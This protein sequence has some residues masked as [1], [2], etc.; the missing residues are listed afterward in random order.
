LAN[1]ETEADVLIVGETGAGKDLVARTMHAM[2]A[3]KNARFVAIDCGAIP[4]PII[5]SELFGHEQGAFTGAVRRRI[6]KFEYDQAGPCSLMKSRACPR[7]CRLVYF[8]SC[9]IAWSREWDLIKGSLSTS[10]S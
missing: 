5:E 4:E 10:G 6:G 9:K 7:T 8:A 1:A 2:S 3:R